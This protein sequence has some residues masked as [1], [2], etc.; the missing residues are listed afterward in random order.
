MM[1]Q[2]KRV[3]P[4][5]AVQKTKSEDDTPLFFRLLNFEPDYP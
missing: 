4:K 2:A 3:R 1:T 5:I